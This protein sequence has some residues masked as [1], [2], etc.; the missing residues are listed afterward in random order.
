MS[1]VFY[2]LMSSYYVECLD[3]PRF[4]LGKNVVVCKNGRDRTPSVGPS[5]GQRQRLENIGVRASNASRGRT[6]HAD[7]RV[8]HSCVDGYHRVCLSSSA[9]ITLR[10]RRWLKAI[11]DLIREGAAFIKQLTASPRTNGEKLSRARS[12]LHPQ[13]YCFVRDTRVTLVRHLK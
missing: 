7:T 5:V 4:L 11:R 12:P 13:T 3:T 8:D 2:T 6:P 1:L 9:S 10:T